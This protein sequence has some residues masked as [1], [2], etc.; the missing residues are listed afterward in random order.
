MLP[1]TLGLGGG[2]VLAVGSI[3]GS[4][5]P[6]MV[7]L[8]RRCSWACS[9]WHGR[10]IGPCARR[11]SVTRPAWRSAPVCGRRSCVHSTIR[12]G[13][14]CCAPPRR[15]GRIGSNARSTIGSPTGGSDRI[16]LVLTDG[17]VVWD[18]NRGDFDPVRSTAL[19]PALVGRFDDEPRHLDL[20]WARGEEQLDVSHV[21][22]RAAV[23]EL[24][25]PIRNMAREELE[26]EDVRQHR[27]TMLL[28][29]GATTV[30]VLLLVIALAATLVAFQQRRDAQR[31]ST[32][33]RVEAATAEAEARRADA[34]THRAEAVT[35]TLLS[36]QL[37]SGA[38][39][40]FAAGQ[41]DVGLLL[42]VASDR[43]QS[44]PQ[45]RSALLTGLHHA[46]H[47]APVSAWPRSVSAD[48]S[49][50]PRRLD[51]RCWNRGRRA[52]LAPDDGT[53]VRTP[54]QSHRRGCKRP[55]TRVSSRRQG[56]RSVG[57]Q[58]RA[59]TE[60]SRR[61][62]RSRRGLRFPSTPGTVALAWSPDGGTLV[63]A[64]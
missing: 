13:S 28:A 59:S 30:L 3:A 27:R 10:G 40:A 60:R 18:R 63:S 33:A 41:H 4:G 43:L 45:A 7:G 35:A 19:P 5:T 12:S 8:R 49:V 51:S 64:G 54:T 37:A 47:P 11:S 16:L 50:Q 1:R 44:T 25:A 34:E 9:G 6:R 20:R 48:G 52:T 56:A 36:R 17:D 57:Q 61:V 53:S 42:A 32:A 29:R 24:A 15:P 2:I 23:A 38:S 22:F 39:N 46:T 26:A 55:R 58:G 21:R 62:S 14:S 31:A